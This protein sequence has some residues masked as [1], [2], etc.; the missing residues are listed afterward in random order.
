MG[1]TISKLFNNLANKK[2]DINAFLD[3][4][5]LFL[6][7]L[8]SLG[9]FLFIRRFAELH[10][11]LDFLNFPIFIGEVLLLLCLILLFTKWK[12]NHREFPIKSRPIGA[13][14]RCNWPYLALFAYFLFVLLKAFYGY[15]KWGPL[16]FRHAAMFYY[17]L[18]AVFGYYFYRRS[19]FSNKKSVFLALLLIFIPRFIPFYG[20]FLFI[21]FL[22]V[23]VL[24]KAYPHKIKRYALLSLLL[25]FTPYDLMFNTA[26]SILVA[27]VATIIFIIFVFFILA[28]IRV[29]YK[30][31]IIALAIIS[32]SIALIKLGDINAVKSLIRVKELIK[33][34][35]EYN[36]IILEKKDSF[37]MKELKT[38]KLYDPDFKLPKKTPTQIEIVRDQIDEVQAKIKEAQTQIQGTQTQIGATESPVIKEA[39]V[40]IEGELIQIG[41]SQALI[42]E[43]QALIQEAPTQITK[44]EPIQVI[45]ESEA[46]I[47]EA[48]TQIKRTQ[49]LIQ[50]AP[51]QITKAEPIQ[52]IKESGT[53][54]ETAE[55][56]IPESEARIQ[57]AQAQIQKAQAQIQKSQ[58]R[59]QELQDKVL[60]GRPLLRNIRVAYNN[61]VFRIFIWQDMLTQLEEERPLLGFDFGKPFRSKNLEVL[62]WGTLDWTRD[63]WITAHNSY[64]HII[65]RA[66]IIGILFILTIFLILFLMIKKAMKQKSI[67]GVLL[68]GI[69]INW[70]VSA[71]FLVFLELPYN[72][73]LFWTLFGMTFAYLMSSQR[74]TNKAN[75]R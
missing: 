30:F 58:V 8:Y 20:H 22:L 51:T 75:V 42:E 36:A 67:T 72:A 19:F 3:N 56:R 4:T 40:Q 10:I 38:V 17:P 14:L 27:N 28:K 39:L 31:A 64:L 24:V 49:A 9:S 29:R 53:Q 45:K 73:V 37:Q 71:N 11:Q 69:L 41:I 23:F 66:G 57:K 35:H 63:G 34:Y 7:G 26:R 6:I 13:F 68:C 21:S 16:A 1:K 43:A 2:P 60:Q 50:E 46:L 59:I 5:G 74:G 47:E 62:N 44:A 55:T 70:L 48:Q 12:I 54:I 65:Y 15:F 18:F 33:T 25:I 32:F 52:V 61:A